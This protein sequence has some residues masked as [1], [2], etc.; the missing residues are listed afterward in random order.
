LTGTF[1]QTDTEIKFTVMRK[2]NTG[3][4]KD[5]MIVPDKTTQCAWALNSITSDRRSK[6]TLT[7]RFTF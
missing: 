6:H 3:D 5:F 4:S 1:E 7:D 2:A